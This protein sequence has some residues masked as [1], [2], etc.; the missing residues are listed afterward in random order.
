MSEYRYTE[1]QE[2]ICREEIGGCGSVVEAVVSIHKKTGVTGFTCP[3]CDKTQE[4]LEP[5]D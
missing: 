3:K 1:P 4:P 5:L 2:L